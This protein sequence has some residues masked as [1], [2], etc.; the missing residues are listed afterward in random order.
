LTG[1]RRDQFTVAVKHLNQLKVDAINTA[2]HV[3]PL[4]MTHTHT[5]TVGW[6]GV[7]E[8]SFVVSTKLLYVEPG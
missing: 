5:H 3:L 1:D 2:D 6:F 4:L 8:A 7:E